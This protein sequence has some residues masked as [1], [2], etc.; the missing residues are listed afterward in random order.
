MRSRLTRCLGLATVALLFAPALASAW[1]A[2]GHQAVGEIASH[3]LTP[4]AE[5][6]LQGVLSAAGYDSLAEAGYWADAHA[7]LF[8][9]YREYGRRHYVNVDPTA[10][11][12]D[13]DRDCPEDCILAALEVLAAGFRETGRATGARGDDLRFLVH[14][15]EDLHQP[16]HVSHPDDRG[17][18]ETPVS[19]F[20]REMNLHWAWDGGLI[21]RRLADYGERQGVGW[22]SDRRWERWAYDLRLEIGP[23][24]I[25][26]WT[27]TLDPV[28][29]A[30]ESLRLA[31]RYTFEVEPGAALD[32]SYY[33]ETIPVVEERVKV[34]GVRLASLLNDLFSDR[35]MLGD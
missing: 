12:V 3:Y 8:E 11:R 9:R 27:A 10:Q 24:E 23:E 15:V 35:P 5:A 25:R 19:L 28:D 33:E 2:A 14:F 20:G 6:K 21:D 1:G 26:A 17:G 16:L 18:N 13:L 7:R 29:W 4:E 31:R 32:E 22:R 30:E 34:A